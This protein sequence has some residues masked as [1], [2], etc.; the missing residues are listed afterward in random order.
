MAN[1]V[2]VT[3]GLFPEKQ[4]DGMERVATHECTTSLK[5]GKPNSNARQTSPRLS[6]QAMEV[7]R[8]IIKWKVR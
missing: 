3:D 7:G 4:S 2:L 5:N 8:R 6:K 1:C